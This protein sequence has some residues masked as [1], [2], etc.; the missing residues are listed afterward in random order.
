[1]T[2]PDTPPTDSSSSL[3]H[4]CVDR[5][6]PL[7][8]PQILEDGRLAGLRDK[9]WPEHQRRLHV[10]F[11]GGDPRLHRRIATIVRQWEQHAHIRF[12]FEQSP[13][14]PIRVAFVRG[15][16]WAYIGTDALDPNIGRDDPTVNFGWFSPA[17]P[18]DE[19]QR[20]VLHEFGHVLG[21]IHEHQS[22]SASIPWNRDA[23]RAYF[24]GPPNHWSE[25]QVEQNIFARYD[26]EQANASEFDPASIM[27]YPIP[28]EFTNGKLTVGWNRAL[29]Q[30]DRSYVGELYPP[31]ARS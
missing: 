25:A 28:P 6:P 30:Q 26:H 11:L 20:V 7:A 4:V 15:A 19:L 8:P 31:P 21:L 17:T 9:L 1:M 12:V 29:S 3:L 24:A 27:L 13:A 14:A 18:N 16:S 23:V 10:R 22:P 2:T 5:F